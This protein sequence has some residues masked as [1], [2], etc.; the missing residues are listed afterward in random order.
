MA[1]GLKI[2]FLWY[3]IGSGDILYAL[4]STVCYQLEGKKWGSIYPV[5]MKDFYQGKLSWEKSKEFLNEIEDIKEKLKGKPIKDLVWNIEA[6]EELPPWRDNISSDIT[7]LYE[8][9]LTSDGRKL[10]DI[11]ILA[12][13][14]MKELMQD[15]EIESI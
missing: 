9:F 13:N 3:Q 11:I 15:L 7:N 14:D 2:D 12:I 1:V 10:I 8:Y 4:F 6:L 5:F